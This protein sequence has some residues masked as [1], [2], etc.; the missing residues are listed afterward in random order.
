MSDHDRLLAAMAALDETV[1]EIA[2]AIAIVDLREQWDAWASQPAPTR[3]TLRSDPARPSL[4]WAYIDDSGA[5][6]SG[7]AGSELPEDWAETMHPA[8]TADVLADQ[9]DDAVA[10]LNRHDLLAGPE[11]P[12]LKRGCGPILAYIDVTDA[13]A[14]A[15]VLTAL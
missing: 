14:A 6:L 10:A 11:R 1:A 13:D 5:R 12:R 2:E 7:P 8:Y 15:S 3:M 4:T 9:V